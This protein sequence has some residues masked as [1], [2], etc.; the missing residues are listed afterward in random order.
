MSIISIII[1][2]YLRKI[3]QSFN[4]E[5]VIHLPGF[6]D[7]REKNRPFQFFKPLVCII[8]NVFPKSYKFKTKCISILRKYF[9]NN[10]REKM[11]MPKRGGGECMLYHE[12]GWHGQDFALVWNSHNRILNIPLIITSTSQNYF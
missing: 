12:S 5:S 10:V 8:L 4:F 3:Q 7:P 9:N 1:L 6:E 2:R 11:F